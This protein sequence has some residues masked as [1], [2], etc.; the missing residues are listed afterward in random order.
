MRKSSIHL[1]FKSQFSLH[2]IL[3]KD[4]EIN[5]EDVNRNKR[6]LRDY[7]NDYKQEKRTKSSPNKI[8]VIQKIA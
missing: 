8:R 3:S 4:T 5:I 2:H 7:L 6:Y 1:D